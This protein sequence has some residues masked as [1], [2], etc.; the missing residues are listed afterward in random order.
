MGRDSR[1]LEDGGGKSMTG[2]SSSRGALNF[3]SKGMHFG[4]EAS[5][6]FKD[7]DGFWYRC[8]AWRE[9]PGMTLQASSYR[10]ER[11]DWI[12]FVNQMLAMQKKFLLESVDK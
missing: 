1:C 8:E 4:T 11:G 9:R 2:T 3:P 7:E 10:R 5:I 12:P 6:E